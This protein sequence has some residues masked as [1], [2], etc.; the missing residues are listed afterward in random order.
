MSAKSKQ[1]GKKLSVPRALPEIEKDYQQQ[2]LRAGDLQYRIEMEKQELT[3]INARLK[4]L[5]NEGWARKQL[6]APPKADAQ[7]V[8]LPEV[9][10]VSGAV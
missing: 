6:D 8:T 10:P 4:Q 1:Q 5:N 2:V 7:A 9:H 3:N